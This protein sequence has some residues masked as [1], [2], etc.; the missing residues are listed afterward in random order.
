MRR[1]TYAG[2][3]KWDDQNILNGDGWKSDWSS[4]EASWVWSGGSTTTKDI[5]TF[6][7]SCFYQND[8][9]NPTAWVTHCGD[10]KLAGLEQCDNGNTTDGDECSSTCTIE[11]SQKWIWNGGTT[12]TQ[13]NC[14]VWG[15]GFIVNDS[16]NP[17]YWKSIWGDGLRIDSEE[18]DT[19][20]IVNSPCTDNWSSILSGYVRTGGDSNGS[21]S[22]SKW[23]NSF[24][25]NYNQS[26]WNVK[27]VVYS[28]EIIGYL[29]A[30]IMLVGMIS[31]IMSSY[32]FG[33]SFATV[34][35]VI[36][37]AQMLLLTPL[38]EVTVDE[39][40][41][42]FYKILKDV[43]L[44]FWY[45]TTEAVF[46]GFDSI[47]GYDSYAQILW[48]LKVIGFSDGSIIYNLGIL[49][50]VWVLII[51]F[52]ATL[53]L[54]NLIVIHQNS[55]NRFSRMVKIVTKF[56]TFK[57]FI[58]FICLSY[59]LLILGS[60]NWIA[61][62]PRPSSNPGSFTIALLIYS[63]WLAFPTFSIVQTILAMNT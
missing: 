62:N 28:M 47:F 38:I 60:L 42:S 22:C 7:S 5:W 20:G 27:P 24:E 45:V 49:F 36:T 58:R 26:S 53:Q 29:Y 40:V 4:V 13:D 55:N 46:V 54:T 59:V 16:S 32:L 44:G 6:W 15:A 9:E 41:I 17:R 23:H 11:T 1:Y 43:L 56:R 18:W 33:Y 35:S 25:T 8:S 61:M 19:G 30:S 57:L 39:N 31:S 48:Y 12:S 34:F 10:G 52:Y 37:H 63:I 3:E 50:S 14:F 2:T 21:D 51:L